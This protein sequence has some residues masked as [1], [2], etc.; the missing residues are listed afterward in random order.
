MMIVIAECKNAP[1]VIEIGVGFKRSVFAG[2]VWVCVCVG[3]G[4]GWGEYNT[5]SNR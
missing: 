3:G 5:Y 2:C 4:G 1:W